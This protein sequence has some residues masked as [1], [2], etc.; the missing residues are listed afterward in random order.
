MYKHMYMIF[1]RGGARTNEKGDPHE[2]NKTLHA[3]ARLLRKGGRALL[4]PLA[5]E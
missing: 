5:H 3:T 4:E 2:A 1:I